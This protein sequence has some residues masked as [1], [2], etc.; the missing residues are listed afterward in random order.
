MKLIKSSVKLISLVVL[1]LVVV[2]PSCKTISSVQFQSLEAPQIILPADV[3]RIAFVARDQCFPSDSVAQYYS[4]NRVVIKDSIDQTRNMSF[5]SYQGFVENM[6]EFW[7]QDSIPFVRLPKK[8]MPDTIRS[9]EPLSWAK[10]TSICKSN[11]VDVLVVLENILAFTTHDIVEGELYWAV[12]EI[13]YQGVWR[14]YDPLYEKIYDERVVVDSLFMEV[15]DEN[16]QRLVNEKIPSREEMMNEAA[17]ELGKS[18][19]DLISPYWKDVS[20]N[21]FVSG[22]KRLTTAL[23]FMD[24]NEFDTAINMWISLTKET[25]MKLAGRAAYNLAV[26]N[27]MKGDLKNAKGWIRKAMY[28]YKKMKKLPNEYKE[29]EAYALILNSRW[30]N[31]N[32]I[33]RFFG[34]E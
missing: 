10:V 29:I 30:L 9:F 31:G 19:V 26:V 21:Y 2:L 17:Y 24:K 12:N 34:E 32:K 11:Q 23:Y 6:S 3:N 18:Y 22:D 5:N 27:E 14:I 8:I 28:F 16:L 33:K 15:S 7:N 25:D 20:R 4:I 13:Q 1:L